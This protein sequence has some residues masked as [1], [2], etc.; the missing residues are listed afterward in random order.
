MPRIGVMFSYGDDKEGVLIESVNKDSPAAKG[1]F[2]AGD[3]IMEVGGKP[4]KS[5]EVY[6]TLMPSY[7]KGDTI[8]FGVQR[9][10]KRVTLKVTL[11]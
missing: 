1:G 10:G 11:E 4:A 2:K 3:R 7:K 8:E 5:L 9:E 6:M